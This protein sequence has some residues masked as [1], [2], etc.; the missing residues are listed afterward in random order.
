MIT[1]TDMSASAKKFG[2][3]YEAWMNPLCKKI[4]LPLTA[5][6]IFMFFA[7]TTTSNIY[8]YRCSNINWTYIIIVICV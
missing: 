2:A 1:I 5:L 6:C 7:T 4:D 3:V 8:I